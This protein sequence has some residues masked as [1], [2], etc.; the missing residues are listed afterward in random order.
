VT[1]SKDVYPAHLPEDDSDQ[2]EGR[3]VQ[4]G[5][6]GELSSANPLVVVIYLYTNCQLNDVPTFT[7]ATVVGNSECEEIWKPLNSSL[8]SISDR[9][10]CTLV[11]NGTGFT[12]GDSGGNNTYFVSSNILTLPYGCLKIVPNTTYNQYKIRNLEITKK[13]FKTFL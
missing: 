8:I 12:S 6:W 4:V 3:I 9:T 7:N 13:A 5:G 10:L 1:F 11:K 2:F